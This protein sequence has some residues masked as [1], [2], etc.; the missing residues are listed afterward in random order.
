MGL[1]DVLQKFDCYKRGELCFKSVVHCSERKGL[2]CTPPAGY[3]ARFM[4][5]MKDRVFEFVPE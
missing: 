4:T 2:S 5:H 1:I 3:R